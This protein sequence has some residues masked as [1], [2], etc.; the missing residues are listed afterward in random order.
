MFSPIR[1]DNP[2]RSRARRGSSAVAGRGSES[3]T[4]AA[5]TSGR[6]AQRRRADRWTARSFPPERSR[7]SRTGAPRRSSTG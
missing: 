5:G 6:E 3:R 4:G 1:V 7:P 2:G